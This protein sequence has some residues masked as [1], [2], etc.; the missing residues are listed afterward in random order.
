M[1][2]DNSS[3][4]FGTGLRVGTALGAAF[5]AGMGNS[6]SDEDKP[7]SSK[8]TEPNPS[9]A[10]PGVGFEPTRADSAQGGLSPSRLHSATRARMTAQ[11]R[12][13]NSMAAPSRVSCSETST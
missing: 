9:G 4:D 10:V 6:S 8:P 1:G 13:S 7:T 12:T 2:K 5:G 11:G 3:K